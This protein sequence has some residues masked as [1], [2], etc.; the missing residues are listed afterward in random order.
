MV[1]SCNLQYYRPRVYLPELLRKRGPQTSDPKLNYRTPSSSHLQSRQRRL[2]S[3]AGADDVWKA[4]SQLL[5][6]WH[7]IHD[8]NSRG[9]LI[10][11]PFPSVVNAGRTS[12]L[13]F[14]PFLHIRKCH[15]RCG[16]YMHQSDHS[17]FA[18]DFASSVPFFHLTLIMSARN[19]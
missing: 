3:I 6:V 18:A 1:S 10:Q 7:C 9:V 16:G 12:H 5:P 11:F 15:V 8:K 2:R 19:N 14:L 17:C 4:V 13:G